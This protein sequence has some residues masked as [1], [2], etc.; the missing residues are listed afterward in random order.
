[1]FFLLLPRFYAQFSLQ[2]AVFVG[3]QNIFAPGR[4]PGTLATPLSLGI[5]S[6]VLTIIG[7]DNIFC[8]NFNTDNAQIRVKFLHKGASIKH[9]HTQGWVCYVQTFCEH[10]GVLQMRTPA[11]L[12]AKIKL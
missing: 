7:F 1:M 2:T 10:G 6:S 12:G 4:R 9:V 8:V 5:L 3:G 11:L